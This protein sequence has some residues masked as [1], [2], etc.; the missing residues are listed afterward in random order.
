MAERSAACGGTFVAGAQPDGGFGVR[1][2]LP[3][4][5]PA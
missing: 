3:L 2:Q 4:R 1:A 5:A